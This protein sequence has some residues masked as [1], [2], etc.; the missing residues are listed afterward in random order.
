VHRLGPVVHLLGLGSYLATCIAGGP[1]LGYFIDKWL[2]TEPAFTMSGLAFGL[3]IGFV[4]AYRMVTLTLR[5]MARET[6]RLQKQK[7]K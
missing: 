2:G 4:G 6:A 1:T 5:E 7:K 3:L